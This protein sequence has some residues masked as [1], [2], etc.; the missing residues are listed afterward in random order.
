MKS[1]LNTS[2]E[3]MV[4]NSK[5]NAKQRISMS[6]ADKFIR[7]EIETAKIVKFALVLH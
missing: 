1:Q 7:N 3:M 5:F 6:Y 2:S 4:S